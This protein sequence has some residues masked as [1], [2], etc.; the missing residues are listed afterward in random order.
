MHDLVYSR[1][2]FPIGKK[3]SQ[4]PKHPKLQTVIG[5]KRWFTSDCFSFLIFFKQFTLSR[6]KL[7]EI[8]AFIINP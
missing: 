1:I 4:P 5:K 8:L 7:F 2:N 3:S 6:F